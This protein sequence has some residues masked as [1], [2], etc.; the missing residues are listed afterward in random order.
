[1]LNLGGYHKHSGWINVNIQPSSFGHGYVAEVLRSIGDLHGIPDGSVD[2]LY[3]SHALEHI[4]LENLEDTLS[5]WSR[6]LTPEGILFVS[7]PD[8]RVMAR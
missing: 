4:K 8:L 2:A 6:V 1:M 3:C 5:E 7:V